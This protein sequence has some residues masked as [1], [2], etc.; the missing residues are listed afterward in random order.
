MDYAAI[1]L[2]I[3]GWTIGTTFRLRFLVGIVLLVLPISFVAALSHG[4]G[5]WE[6]VL[7]I[8]I[9]QAILQG[10][11]FLGVISRSFFSFVQRKAQAEHLRD[12]KDG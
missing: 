5:L 3:L 8:V 12:P 9:P 1:T 6:K 4:S 7:I 10:G 2:A 11:Y